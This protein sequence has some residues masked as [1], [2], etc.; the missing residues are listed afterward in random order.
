MVELFGDFAK[1]VGLTWQMW[2]GSV[3]IGLFSL[4]W[5]VL[6]RLVPVDYEAGRINLQF[7]K[8]T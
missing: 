5:G 8:G 3:V 7:D 6:V 2:L 4:P 1:T